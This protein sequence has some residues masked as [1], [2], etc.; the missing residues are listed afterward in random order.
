VDS[1]DPVTCSPESGS[2]FPVGETTVTCTSK[3]KAGNTSH[4]SFKVTVTAQKPKDTTAPELHV[5]SNMTV[6]AENASGA[7]ASYTVTATDPDNS[8]SELTIECSPASGSTFP[9]GETTVECSAKDPAGNTSHAS[10]KIT[11][12]DT[13]PPVIEKVPSNITVE[14]SS[15]AGAVV[16]Y[17][18]PTATDDVDSTDPVTCSPESGSVFPVGE[19]TVTCTSKDK[20]GNTSHAS[21]KVTVTAQKAADTAAPELHVPA[22]MT[23]S[24]E[25]ASGAKVSYTVTATDP[26]NNAGELTVECSPTSG[27]VFPLGETTVSCTAKDPAGNMSH[28][29]FTIAVKQQVVTHES[30]EAQ[31]RKLLEEVESSNVPHG[32]RVK[33][34]ALL[35]SALHGLKGHHA[36]A[37]SRAAMAA[38]H[39]HRKHKGHTRRHH[40][41][42]AGKGS[43]GANA[44]AAVC[45]MLGQFVREI[46][47]DQQLPN[48]KIAA[49]L[50]SSWT[51][52]ATGIESSL[53]CASGH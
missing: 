1:T 13:T 44:A 50:A 5:P 2:V 16:T 17:T 20:A 26:D 25:G 41:H 4:A 33:L 52:K 45:R 14:A 39:G 40:G 7:K 9:L 21:F 30:A 47:H 34:A 49:A 35:K 11:A 51:D 37:A 22:S 24:A 27:S 6:I 31:I 23:V 36:N 18:N 38:R 15:G 12:K 46:T 10:F 48:P 32:V 42:K 8:A 28:A 3:D 53:G 29:S 19:T 43:H